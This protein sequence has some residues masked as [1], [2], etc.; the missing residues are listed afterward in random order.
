MSQFSALLATVVGVYE[1]VASKATLLKSPS[2]QRD[3]N[4]APLQKDISKLAGEVLRKRTVEQVSN[5]KGAT[6]LA[7][8]VGYGT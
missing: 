4:A 7:I 8:E 1:T 6:P 2:M 5:Q 3:A